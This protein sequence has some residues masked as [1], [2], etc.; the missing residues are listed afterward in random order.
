MPPPAASRRPPPQC[1]SV[2]PK[3]AALVPRLYRT[4]ILSFSSKNWAVKMLIKSFFLVP[5]RERPPPAAKRGRNCRRRRRWRRPSLSRRPPFLWL[6]PS[7]GVADFS[8]Y[9]FIVCSR[10]SL[11]ASFAGLSHSSLPHYSKPTIRGDTR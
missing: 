9:E 4:E 8:F 5:K 2:T 1:L 11:H 7:S 10:F 6:F 3:A